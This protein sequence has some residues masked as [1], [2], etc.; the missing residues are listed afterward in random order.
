[1]EGQSNK[2]RFVRMDWAIKRIL[3]DK[4]NFVV[5]EGFLSE[6]IGDDIHITQLLE[7]EGNKH[8]EKDKYNRVDLKAI[9]DN[10]EHFIFE[11]QVSHQ[12]D[13]MERMLYGVAK[14]VTEQLSEGDVYA[15]IAKVYSINIVYFNLGKG[16]DYIY[17][18]QTIFRGCHDGSEL[19]LS[20]RERDYY[21]MRHYSNYFPEYWLIRVN[22]FNK[23]AKTPLDE[24]MEYLKNGYISDNP[25][26][27]GLKQARQRL[28]IMTMTPEERDNYEE[29]LRDIASYERDF[30]KSL[31]ISHDEGVQMGMEKG[32]LVGKEEGKK[33]GKKE[34][35]EEIAR[36]MLAKGMPID[37]I[38]ELTSLSIEDIKFLD[39]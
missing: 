15:K 39:K 8:S 16:D 22:E 37:L 4:A 29:Y 35:A 32:I 19:Q 13:F 5:L 11:I 18:G 20:N 7:S 38:S 31:R 2:K 28:D 26:A 3:R 36:L 1:M 14:A 25:K 6:L 33:E 27:K 10:G 34:S 17:R 9:N 23:V 24:W 30:A 21:E 12:S